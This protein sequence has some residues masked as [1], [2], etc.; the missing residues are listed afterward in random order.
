MGDKILRW[1]MLIC[2]SG[3]LSI[4]FVSIFTNGRYGMHLNKNI[5]QAY[6]QSLNVPPEPRPPVVQKG[7]SA[8]K[9]DCEQYYV[10]EKGITEKSFKDWSTDSRGSVAAQIATAYGLLYQNCLARQNRR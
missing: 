5:N 6:A 3:A 2:A 9:E 10:L 1:V 8:P 4:I 7:Q